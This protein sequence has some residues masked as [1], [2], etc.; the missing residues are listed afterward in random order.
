MKFAIWS[1]SAVNETYGKVYKNG[2]PLG[3]EQHHSDSGV[4]NTYS[5]DI[6][7]GTIAAGETLE[8]WCMVDPT[9]TGKCKEFRAYYKDDTGAVVGVNS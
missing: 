9:N 8:L 2:A 1:N 4:Y 6:D 7:V 5:E 3:A